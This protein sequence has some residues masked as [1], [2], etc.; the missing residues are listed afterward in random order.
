MEMVVEQTEKVKVCLGLAAV[1]FAERF[2]AMVEALEDW[3]RPQVMTSKD[4]LS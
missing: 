2:G 4:P 1:T 3:M